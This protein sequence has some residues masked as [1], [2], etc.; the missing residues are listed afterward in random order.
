MARHRKTAQ[1]CSIGLQKEWLAR[2]PV[3]LLSKAH[4]Q[5]HFANRF[6][7][8]LTHSFACDTELLGNFLKRIGVFPETHED[9][10]SFALK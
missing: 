7:F 3:S 9:D 1:S 2:V 8:N 4:I 5:A 10:R 6:C